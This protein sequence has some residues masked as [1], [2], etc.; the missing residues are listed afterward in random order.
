MAE[1]TVIGDGDIDRDQNLKIKELGL[2]T[3]GSYCK[4]FF[5]EGQNIIT[6]LDLQWL[7]QK[8]VRG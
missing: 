8:T 2:Y 1:W 5:K 6:L 4:I 3:V 7:E